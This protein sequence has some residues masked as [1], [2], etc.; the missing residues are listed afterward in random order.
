MK[1]AESDKMSTID[2]QAL[3][4]NVQPSLAESRLSQSAWTVVCRPA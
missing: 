3:L 2:G 4:G 1:Q